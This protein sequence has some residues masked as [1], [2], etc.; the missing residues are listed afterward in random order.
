MS[1]YDYVVTVEQCW[2][3]A[4]AQREAVARFK[5]STDAI[6]YAVWIGKS[7]P[8]GFH[9]YQNADVKTISVVQTDGETGTTIIDTLYTRAHVAEKI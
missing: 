6:D 8:E 4:P 1:T 2:S 5:N 3:D 7:H 9:V